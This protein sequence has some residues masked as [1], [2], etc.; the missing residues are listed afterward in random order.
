MNIVF[1]AAESVPFTKVGGLA[2]VVGTLTVELHRM[3]H[4]VKLLLPHHGAIDDERHG[5]EQI[6]SF[7]MPWHGGEAEVSVGH[8]TSSGVPV[9]LQRC[10]PYF[11]PGETFVY[12]DDEGIDVGR[13]LFFSSAALAFT[14]RL[15]NEEHWQPD[16]FHVHD[17]HTGLIPY[18]LRRVYYADDVLSRAA[19]LLTIHN[20]KYQGWGVGWHLHEAGLPPVDHSLLHAMDKTNN[21]LAVGLAYSTALNTVSPRYAQEIKEESGG[22]GLDG[23]LEAR[24][25]HL[26]GILNGID[27]DRWNPTASDA[28]PDPFDGA[29]L[30]ARAASKRAQQ[31]RLRLP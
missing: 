7:K 1:A 12:S 4:R 26:S 2:D 6:D 20:M 17:W 9:Y 28:V 11:T 24:Q 16:L 30:D 23:L 27:T 21:S 3:G 18:L 19:V 22:Y 8:T 10:W 14:S 25:A 13:F 29:P 15:A 5:I 31:E